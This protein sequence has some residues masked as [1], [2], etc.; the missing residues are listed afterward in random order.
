[1]AKA[2]LGGRRCACN[3]PAS[4]R[5]NGDWVC[6][7]CIRKEKLYYAF[8]GLRGQKQAAEEQAESGIQPEP[9]DLLLD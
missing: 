6:E 9:I 5:Y 8:R 1:M 7:E 3:E 2:K 4:R